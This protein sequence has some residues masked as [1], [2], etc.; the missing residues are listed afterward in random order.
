[1]IIIVFQNSKKYDNNIKKMKK[2]LSME[3]LNKHNYKLKDNKAT[4][5]KKQK[6]ILSQNYVGNKLF[7]YNKN[8]RNNYFHNNREL[9]PKNLKIKFIAKRK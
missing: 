3:Y 5:N 8:K 7:E 1:M 6:N 2:N 4:T 9:N